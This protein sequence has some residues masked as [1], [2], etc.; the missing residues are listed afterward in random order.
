MN[1]QDKEQDYIRQLIY[2]LGKMEPSVNFHKNI[3][4]KLNWKRSIST[5]KPVISTLAW[6]IIGSI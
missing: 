3:L 1:D 2:E 5:Y 6:K 4:S